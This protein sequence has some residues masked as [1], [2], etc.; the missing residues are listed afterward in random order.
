MKKYSTFLAFAL[1]GICYG[2]QKVSPSL[3]V[4]VNTYKANDSWLLPTL[5][6]ALSYYSKNYTAIF[7]KFIYSFD[8]QNFGRKNVYV[9]YND[10]M[11]FD[12][13][14]TLIMD[15]P[16]AG[17]LNNNGYNDADLVGAVLSIIAG[18]NIDFSY[19]KKFSKNK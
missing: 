17:G 6:P 18:E 13:G 16:V 15:M 11:Y 2:Q 10:K 3:T 19:H 5:N 12:S 8:A 1:C 14:R 9:G 4:A 7:G